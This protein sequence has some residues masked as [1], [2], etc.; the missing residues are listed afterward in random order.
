VVRARLCLR[1]RLAAAPVV[2]VALVALA[3]CSAT[4]EIT[5]DKPYSASD[6]VR[7]EVGDVTAENLFLLSAAKGDPGAL[8]GALTN[9][10]DQS[11]QVKIAGEQDSDSTDVRV[12]A[13]QTVLLGADGK[14]VQLGSVPVEPGATTPLTLTTGSA[15]SVT[16]EVPVLDGTLPEYATLVPTPSPTAD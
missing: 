13:G 6:G 2:A 14:D 15:G 8:Q 3:G 5:T 1:S 4:N 12:P 9:N 11:I 16:L 7:A 10:G